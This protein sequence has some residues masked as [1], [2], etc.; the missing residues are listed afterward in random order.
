MRWVSLSRESGDPARR[1]HLGRFSDPDLRPAV[2]EVDLLVRDLA[3]GLIP[4]NRHKGELFAE[5]LFEHVHPPGFEEGRDPVLGKVRV[6]AGNFVRGDLF[7]KEN[8]GA[9]DM[10]KV[11][12]VE[13]ASR[14]TR[15][16]RE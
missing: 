6:D 8:L 14:S 3:P 4:G 11:R 9:K 16:Q 13:G 1:P 15:D 2:H 5:D 7:P 12:F 10:Q